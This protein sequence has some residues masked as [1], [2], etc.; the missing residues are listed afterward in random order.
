[1]T[2][3]VADHNS[4]LAEVRLLIDVTRQ[5]VDSA[6]NA[7]LTQLY[8][9]IGSRISF[10]LL[11]GQRGEYGKQ[12]MAELARQLTADFGKRWSELQLRHCLR[13]AENFQDEQILSA[14]QRELSWLSLSQ[15]IQSLL[16]IKRIV[17]MLCRKS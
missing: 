1:M 4:L 10:E 15:L 17:V 5:Q 3:P 12:V 16:A 13:L 11:Q 6:F 9:H 2:P 8:W 14:V 7:E